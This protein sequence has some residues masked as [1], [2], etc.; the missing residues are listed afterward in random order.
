[1]DPQ[2]RG[3]DA[4]IKE[5]ITN[6]WHRREEKIC[7]QNVMRSLKPRL[8]IQALVICFQEHE[9]HSFPF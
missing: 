8:R 3:E 1:M 6:G 9:I 4:A 2:M 5:F 7:L